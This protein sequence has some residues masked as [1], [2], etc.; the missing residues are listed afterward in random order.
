MKNWIVSIGTWLALGLTLCSF[1]ARAQPA[2]LEEYWVGKAS[3]EFVRKWTPANSGIQ[4]YGSSHIEVAGSTWYLFSRHYLPDLCAGQNFAK[5][6]I[7]VLQ[8]NDRGATWSQP[9][10]AVAPDSV[11]DACMA[12][13]GDAFYDAANDKW[14]LLYQCAGDDR[15]WRGC[16]AERAGSS[17]MGA[18]TKA[19]APVIEAGQLWGPI[20]NTSSDDCV[21]IPGGPGR[22]RDEGTFN[23][24]HFDGT[25]YW[26]SFHGY[27]GHKLGFRGVA[28]TQDF[29]HWIA[30]DPAQ[31]LPA[32][33][34]LDS[35][36]A[37]SWRESWHPGGPIGAGA[38]S[39][40][41]SGSLFYMLA[42][43]A[44]DNLGCTS[45]QHWDLGLFRAG[46]LAWTTWDQ[47]PQGNP[48]VY[49][50]REEE[51][52][53][54]PACNVQ[55]PQLFVDASGETFLKYYHLSSDDSIAGTY[56][57]KLKRSYNALV[58]ADL[59]MGD[60]RAWRRLPEGASNLLVFRAL[61]ES[62]D[63]TPF[64]ATNCGTNPAPCAAGQS[65]YQ[66]VDLAGRTASRFEF[67]G[68]FSTQGGGGVL[69]LAV[70]QLDAGYQP[71]HVDTVPAPAGVG[72]YQSS[73]SG[74]Y[75]IRPNARY[76]RYQFYLDRSDVTYLADDMYLNLY[77]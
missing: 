27:D 63:G 36:D 72:A 41:R 73:A 32:D 51:N 68:K 34:I 14:R 13:D 40:V 4:N 12:T 10:M 21:T 37:Q 24:S 26:V 45:G 48:I 28:K 38:A 46:S 57:F 56:L 2:T 53:A 19:P 59:W 35:H 15:V 44:D 58:N 55:Y 47:P 9:V 66:D 70:W 50:S 77:P 71:L 60:E 3:W 25:Y 33:A 22:V 67:G 42:E 7:A 49:S 74:S 5:F 29:V 61:R 69:T 76:L 65:V 54:I 17:P 64:M 23:I 52:G 6:G 16:Y 18:F 43:M 20:C 39:I 75:T 8:S 11:A 62:L 1:Q 30:G 31:G